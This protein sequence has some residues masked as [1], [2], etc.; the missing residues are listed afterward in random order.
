M[1][2]EVDRRAPERTNSGPTTRDLGPSVGPGKSTRTGG[3]LAKTTADVPPAAAPAQKPLALTE[4]PAETAPDGPEAAPAAVQPVPSAPTSMTALADEASTAAAPEAP[5]ATAPPAPAGSSPTAATTPTAQG[6]QP[7]APATGAPAPGNA[8]PAGAN[9]PTA[10]PSVPVPG[11][12]RVTAPGGLRVRRT[13]DGASPFNVMGGLKFHEEVEAHA[14]HGDWIA[15]TYKMMTAYVYGGYVEAAPQAA[16]QS[17]ATNHALPSHQAPP[18]HVATGSAPASS[19]GEPSSGSSSAPHATPTGAPAAQAP[20]QPAAGEFTTLSGNAIAKTT[21]KEA[22][23]LN[24]IRADPR[25]FSPAWLVT[26][27]RAL[28]VVDATGA[29]NTETLRAMR[30]HAHRPSLDAAGILNE[31]FLVGIVPGAPFMTSEHG[32]ADQEA[33]GGAHRPADRAA[34]AVGYASYA[35]YQADWVAISFLGRSLGNPRA[36]SSGRGHPYL[37]ERVRVAEAFLRQ[38]HP[39]LNDEAV[40]RAIGW[41]GVGNAAYADDPGTMMSHQHTMGLAIDIDPGHNPYIFDE[42]PRGLTH[43]QAMW[44][45]EAFEQMFRVATKIYG[46]DP[47]QPDTLMTW[48]KESSSEELIQRVHA[49]SEAFRQYLELSTRP[50]EEILVKLVA[51]GYTQDEARAELPAV[52]RSAERFHAGGG[53][54]NAQTLTNIKDE[55]LVALRDVAGLSWGGIE[56][57]MRENGDFM[58]FDCRNTSFGYAVYS[59]TAPTNRT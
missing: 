40:I 49:T 13:P 30:T 21:A 53:R 15:I 48:S 14:H 59:K 45:I 17:A 1:S 4:T 54:Q 3:M 44:W 25:R 58:H 38:R 12:I 31:P 11:I 27:Q 41:N 55:L 51:A 28:G 18:P 20:T 9:A 57:S 36:G 39:G 52:Q 19:P 29:M 37:A 46:G 47:I 23:V 43:D 8:P 2:G 5:T 7:V 33:A 10:A 34:Q 50:E 24:A 6:A 26:A 56:M 35:A 22:A 32:F 16:E 42:H